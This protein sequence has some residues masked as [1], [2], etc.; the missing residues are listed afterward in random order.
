[1]CSH[2]VRHL[3]VF[4][5]AK[6]TVGPNDWMLLEISYTNFNNVFGLSELGTFDVLSMLTT[7][8]YAVS[9]SFCFSTAS[10]EA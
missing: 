5:I 10:I 1:M 2:N 8:Y 3:A 7:I 9:T 6:R 4:H